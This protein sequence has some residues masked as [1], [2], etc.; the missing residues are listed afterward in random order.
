ME[1]TERTN[2]SSI[3]ARAA[4]VA[5]VTAVLIALILVYVFAFLRARPA[6][7]PA[8]ETVRGAGGAR[9]ASLTLQ[10][11]AAL[12]SGPQPD[13]VSYLVRDKSG[14]WHHSTF[15]RL[16]AHATIHVTVFQ[17]D[18]D[19]GLRNPFWARPRGIV[20]NRLTLDGKSLDVINPDDASHT[21]AVPDLGISV[22][23]AGVSDNAKNQCA[24][25]APCPMS[26]AHRTIKFTF[27]T[28]APGMYRWQ[29]F[30][31]CAAG[32]YFGFGGPMQTIGFMDGYLDVV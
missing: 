10:T 15:F 30:V 2:S 19:S 8:A 5:L 26:T 22:P 28:G 12:G 25:P 4:I 32:L 9:Q 7:V 20:G 24:V 14:H 21:F 13:W 16:P 3:T 6:T 17:F 29:C 27:H 1:S 11:V 23:L 31:P 18:G